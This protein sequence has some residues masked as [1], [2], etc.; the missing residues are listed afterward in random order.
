MYKIF[1]L[2]YPDCSQSDSIF[3]QFNWLVQI[4]KYLQVKSEVIVTKYSISD[5][6]RVNLRGGGGGSGG[7]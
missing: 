1:K 7:E 6:R 2:N 4:S 3:I 5:I